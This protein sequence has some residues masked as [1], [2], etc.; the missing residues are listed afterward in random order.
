MSRTR[1]RRIERLLL[2]LLIVLGAMVTGTLIP[3]MPLLS[4]SAFIYSP[5]AAQ[6]FLVAL[7][8]TVAYLFLSRG[9]RKRR[10]QFGICLGIACVVGSGTIFYSHS[11]GESVS[12]FRAFVPLSRFRE[13]PKADV[14]IR[15]SK[16]DSPS[17][18]ADIYKPPRLPTG[19]RA[20]TLM[21]VHGG[22]WDRLDRTHR[23]ET[24]RWLANQGYLVV[25]ID[26]TLATSDSPTWKL[27]LVELGCALEWTIRS[28]PRFG[29]D[30]NQLFLYGESAGGALVLSLGY[31]AEKGL[32]EASCGRPAI[33]V[34]GI[35]AVYPAVDLQSMYSNPNP[36]LRSRSRQAVR[37]YIG[38]S[39]E[40]LP[41][42]TR[43][44][45]PLSYADANSPPAM[46]VIAE[47]DH[48]VPTSGVERFVR[49]AEASGATIHS[50]RFRARRSWL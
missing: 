27:S 11:N 1:W 2:A 35:F 38:G 40:K 33:R 41:D 50:S 39:P 15:Y 12:L 48:L 24:L 49:A 28:A 17:L 8:V 16:S 43:F 31:A 6:G 42:R 32:P 10:E 44:V 22:G 14:T 47:S 18:L 21:Y 25:S 3:A 20:P 37:N 46:V 23:S 5:F 7:L 34:A 13:S 30:S 19:K 9:R 45:S 26:Y 29:G 4:L 36:L